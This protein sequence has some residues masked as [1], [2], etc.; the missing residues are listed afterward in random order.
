M[1]EPPAPN[2]DETR[3]AARLDLFFNVL[4]VVCILIFIACVAL[5]PELHH[6]PANPEDGTRLVPTDWD[7]LP[8]QNEPAHRAAG[9]SREGAT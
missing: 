1:P 9:S 2:P 6:L 4:Q 8:G 3:D 5:D 7:K